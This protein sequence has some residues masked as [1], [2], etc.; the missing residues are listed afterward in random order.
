MLAPGFSIT[1]TD[2]DGSHFTQGGTSMS[3]PHAAGLAALLKQYAKLKF[4]RN[5]TAEQIKHN[6]VT[7]GLMVYDSSSKLSFP[8]LMH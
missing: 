6:M 1:A 4:S 5:L 2:H 3:T 8:R 7:S